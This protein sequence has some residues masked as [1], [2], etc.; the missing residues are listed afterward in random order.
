[1]DKLVI[2]A[3]DLVA[4]LVIL[5]TIAQNS[6]RGFVTG[7]FKFLG[8]LTAFFGAAFLSKQ[9]AMIVYDH[10]LKTGGRTGAA[11]KTVCECPRYRN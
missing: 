9:G 2:L 10:F 1:M 5:L 3:Y 8:R 11:S 4:V 6:Q 7:I